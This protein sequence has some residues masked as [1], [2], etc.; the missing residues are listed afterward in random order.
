MCPFKTHVHILI[1]K[2]RYWEVGTLGDV[3]MSQVSSLVTQVCVL[4]KETS[5]ARCLPL[6][7]GDVRKRSHLQ[8]EE[9]LG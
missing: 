9:A 3:A 7:C 6:L 5:K 4:K 8:E 1:S 2:W